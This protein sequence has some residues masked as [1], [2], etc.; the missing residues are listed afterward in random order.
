MDDTLFDHFKVLC[1][2]R[3]S[4]RSFSDEKIPR[5]DIEKVLMIAKTSPYSGNRK[6]WD[7]IVIDDPE[8]I[9]E[10]ANVVKDKL[11]EV[12]Q[13]IKKEFQPM[14]TE[15]SDYYVSF[16]TAP[17]LLIPVYRYGQGLEYILDR[18]NKEIMKLDQETFVKS[19]SCVSMIALLAMESLGYGGC[20]VDGATIAGEEISKALGLKKR[21]KIGAILPMGRK[22]ES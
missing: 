22:K 10:L 6:D 9:K 7:I 4:V 16:E 8:K 11:V 18:P 21:M 19:I 14:Y 17:V 2:K 3:R 12:I 20:F 15:Y 5:E 13:D 1:E